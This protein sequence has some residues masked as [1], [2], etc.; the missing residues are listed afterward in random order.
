M[1][2]AHLRIKKIRQDKSQVEYLVESFDFNEEKEWEKVGT[3]AID[4]AR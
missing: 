3:L 2:F 4:T 1:S